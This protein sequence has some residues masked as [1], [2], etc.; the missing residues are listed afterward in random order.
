MAIEQTQAPITVD[1]M[2]NILDGS[3]TDHIKAIHQ[4]YKTSKDYYNTNNDISNNKRDDTQLLSAMLNKGNLAGAKDL[5]RRADNRASSNF[6]QILID[7]EAGYLATSDPSIDLGDKKLNNDVK[8]AL[9]DKFSL[10]LNKLV[11]DASLAGQAWLHYWKDDKGIHYGV[12]P[13]DQIYPIYDDTLEDN[14]L[15]VVR[16]YKRF[17]NQGKLDTIV[18]YWNSETCTV[19]KEQDDANEPLI[20][21]DDEFTNV[22][23]TAEYATGTSAVLKHGLGDVPF[24]CFNKNIDKKPELSKYKDTIDIY[25][26]VFNGYAN[27]LEDIQQTILILKGFGGEKISQLWQNIREDK[28]IKLDLMGTGNEGVDT[29]NIDIPVDAKNAMLDITKKKIFDDGQ[30]IDP[31]SFMTN[32]AIS[33]KAIKGLYASLELKASTTEK[34]FRPALAKLVRAILRLSGRNDWQT[35]NISQKWTR[36]AVQNDLEQSEIVRNIASYTSKHNIAKINPAVDDVDQELNYQ[37]EEEV[38]SPYDNGQL[39]DEFA[40][41]KNDEK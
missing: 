10:V 16:V 38:Q 34:Y 28:A 23:V 32:S 11:V 30:G 6:H 9:G 25:D 26:K 2:K 12:I 20:Y 27:D 29:L 17:N 7:Q 8:Q 35:I 41:K 37:K 21:C 14:L 33:G 39:I 31:Q 24:I 4:Q 15:A 40:K 5:I 1:A 22:D 36:T 3:V 13:P 19:F 18:E